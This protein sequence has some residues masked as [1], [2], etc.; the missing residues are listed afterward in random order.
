MSKQ[1]NIEILEFE[2]T[3]E[4]LGEITYQSCMRDIARLISYFEILQQYT[5]DEVHGVY[6][7]VLSQGFSDITEVLQE[8]ARR[9]N[10]LFKST[11][12]E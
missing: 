6:N 1:K 5:L 7:P 10:L 9:Y 2:F 8:V 4:E 11:F 12:C 3:P